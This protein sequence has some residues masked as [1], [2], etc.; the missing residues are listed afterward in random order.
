M[1]K[2]PACKYLKYRVFYATVGFDTAA[3]ANPTYEIAVLEALRERLRCKEIWVVG[4]N[5]YRDPDED[6]PADF[7]ENRE[8]YSQ[9][10]H[11]PLNADRFITDLQAEM[12]EAL[13][14]FDAGLQKNPSVRIGPQGGGWI[15]LTPLDA[16]PEPPN[17]TALKAELNAI[18]PMT[19]LGSSYNRSM[20]VKSMA[21]AN[22]YPKYRILSL[23]L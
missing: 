1:A 13:S 2:M 7:D 23:Y 18:W 20:P 12:R 21:K 6:L 17:L 4:A 5:R 15:T 8:E 19:S 10:L 22:N 11:L 16:Q 14:T 9:A 3:A